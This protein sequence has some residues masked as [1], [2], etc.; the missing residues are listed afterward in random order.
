M[1]R[2]SVTGM[3]P[4]CGDRGTEAQH[5]PSRPLAGRVG[6]VSEA[7]ADGVGGLHLLRTRGAPPDPSPPL[8]SLAGGGE[9]RPKGGS[10]SP[11]RPSFLSIQHE[12][13]LL[14]RRRVDLED[15]E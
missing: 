14:S 6:R 13:E 10:P 5:L 11:R 8:A 15:L 7:N 1:P 4:Y 12:I 2:L 9:Q 3:S